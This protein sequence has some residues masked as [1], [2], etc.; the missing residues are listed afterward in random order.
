LAL[1]GEDGKLEKLDEARR[2][3]EVKHGQ[4]M[5]DQYCNAPKPE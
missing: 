2:A 1:E 3:E 4:Q 5:V